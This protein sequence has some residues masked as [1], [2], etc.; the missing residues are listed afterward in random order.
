MTTMLNRTVIW[1][2]A[3]AAAIGVSGLA[4]AD[5][6]HAH[7][8]GFDGTHHVIRGIYESNGLPMIPGDI[9][10]KT[11]SGQTVSIDVTATTRVSFEA[12]GSAGSLAS[13]IN[14]GHL[15]ITANVV[16][17]QNQ[18]VALTINAHLNASE[19]QKESP[20]HDPHHPSHHGDP[21]H[22]HQSGDS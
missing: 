16:T 21:S 13:A 2:A 4:L 20:A 19:A 6:H 17:Q 15:W 3:M 8:H 5:G 12:E 14:S 22:H 7:D 18:M 11:P 1:A 9:T 10:L